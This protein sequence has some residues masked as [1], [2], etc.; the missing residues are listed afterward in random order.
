MDSLKSKMKQIYPARGR[1]CKFLSLP[2]ME[3]R[4][5]L[6]SLLLVSLIRLSLWLLPFRMVWRLAQGAENSGALAELLPQ[7]GLR[8]PQSNDVPVP[9]GQERSREVSRIAW[10]VTAASQYIPAASCLTQALATQV[11]LRR[12]GYPAELRIGVTRAPSGTLQA[13]AWVESQGVVVIGGPEAQ[14][15]TLQPIA[16]PGW[17]KR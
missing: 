1:T 6:Q 14:F 13:H 11:L 3:R 7:G 2:A 8:E 4:L 17:K 16:G 5:L 10:A 9:P 12:H 15:Q